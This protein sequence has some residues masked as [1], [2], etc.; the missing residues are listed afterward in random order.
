MVFLNYIEY[1]NVTVENHLKPGGMV[2]IIGAGFN[3]KSPHIGLEKI[4]TGNI[5]TNEGNE[6]IELWCDN[7]KNSENF[8]SVDLVIMCR[9]LMRR[10]SRQEANT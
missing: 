4:Q 9:V 10:V 7:Y 2:L 3:T 5:L 6:P 8:N 1:T